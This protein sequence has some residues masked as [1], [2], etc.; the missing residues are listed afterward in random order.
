LID[1][2]DLYDRPFS[3]FQKSNQKPDITIG[4]GFG[5]S[6]SFFGF[7]D[8]RIRGFPDFDDSRIRIRKIQNSSNGAI[9]SRFD[10]IGIFP[11]KP[12]K[13]EKNPKKPDFP[14][15]PKNPKIGEIVPDPIFAKK[16]EKTPPNSPPSQKYSIFLG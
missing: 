10:S 5:I 4:F 11:K 9:S 6:K 8:P 14:K 15:N 7:V 12:K 1:R 13:T 2:L 3:D 16:H